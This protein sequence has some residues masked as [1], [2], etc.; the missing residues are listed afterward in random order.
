MKKIKN[1]ING[2]VQ[3]NSVNFLSVDDP[4]TGEVISEVV[5]SSIEDFKKY[6]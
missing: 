2:N 6:C 4:S 5:L 3:A 1:Y